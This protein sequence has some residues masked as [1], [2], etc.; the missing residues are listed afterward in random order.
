MDQE[1]L[2]PIV[3]FILAFLSLFALKINA[4]ESKVYCSTRKQL[5]SVIGD[6][7]TDI[8]AVLTV[9]FHATFNLIVYGGVLNDKPFI[10]MYENVADYYRTVQLSTLQTSFDNDEDNKNINL[11]LIETVLFSKNTDKIRIATSIQAIDTQSANTFYIVSTFDQ[12][13]VQQ[14]SVKIRADLNNP[15]NPHHIFFNEFNQVYMFFNLQD[16]GYI[17]KLSSDT[18]QFLY[19]V[20][21]NL[22]AG[23]FKSQISSILYNYDGRLMFFGDAFSVLGGNQVSKFYFGAIDDYSTDG[24]ATYICYVEKAEITDTYDLMTFGCL[25]NYKNEDQ[26][27]NVI[28]LMYWDLSS[29]FINFVYKVVNNASVKKL[30]CA[31]QYISTSGKISVYYQN[32]QSDNSYSIFYLEYDIS[33]NGLDV[34]YYATSYHSIQVGLQLNQQGSVQVKLNSF[35]FLAYTDQLLQGLAVGSINKDASNNQYRAGFIEGSITP[36]S[37]NYMDLQYTIEPPLENTFLILMVYLNSGGQNINAAIENF[38]PINIQK[39]EDILLT[40]NNYWPNQNPQTGSPNLKETLYIEPNQLIT[41][42]L[43]YDCNFKIASYQLDN[44]YENDLVYY[45]A[46]REQEG[47]NY[48][49][50]TEPD[51]FF[52]ETFIEFKQP[53]LNKTVTLSY[54]P[55]SVTLRKKTFNLTYSL[56]KVIVNQYSCFREIPFQMEVQTL[57]EFSFKMLEYPVPYLYYYP[58]SSQTQIVEKTTQSQY[59]VFTNLTK[60]IGT[61]F[62]STQIDFYGQQENITLLQDWQIIVLGPNYYTQYQDS[63]KDVNPEFHNQPQD[64]FMLAGTQRKVKLPSIKNDFGQK[65]I[66]ELQGGQ[67]TKFISLNKDQLVLSPSKEINGQFSINI[68]LRKFSQNSP[69]SS[70]IINVEVEKSKAIDPDKINL[71]DYNIPSSSSSTSI[72][73]K[74]LKAVQINLYLRITQV[75]D[76]LVIQ[77]KENYLFQ[78]KDMKMSITKNYEISKSLPPQIS[79]SLQAQLTKFGDGA[80]SSF[81]SF[82]GSNFAINLLLNLSWILTF[83]YITDSLGSLLSIILFV[84]CMIFPIISVYAVSYIKLQFPIYFKARFSPFDEGVKDSLYLI[85]LKPYL[86]PTKNYFEIFSETCIITIIYGFIPFLDFYKLDDEL[87]MN[88]GYLTILLTGLFIFVNLGYMI[89]LQMGD[90][91][92]KLKCVKQKIQINNNT[93][94]QSQNADNQLNTQQQQSNHLTSIDQSTIFTELDMDQKPI[95]IQKAQKRKTNQRRKTA[96]NMDLHL[97]MPAQTLRKQTDVNSGFQKNLKKVLDIPTPSNINDIQ[98]LKI[99]KKIFGKHHRKQIQINN[100]NRKFTVE[101]F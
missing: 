72:Q 94:M 2:K 55:Q 95:K 99:K 23:A 39:A 9:D 44:C 65:I 54:T 6:Y 63:S 26:T 81:Q 4:L 58:L 34:I 76:K 32:Q 37:W 36:Q 18:L 30:K 1:N 82:M 86:D 12:S 42:L 66:I 62:V 50:V 71:A 61:Y 70:Y 88:L 59:D 98:Q 21:L 13:L 8:S 90:L 40:K 31:G 51:T 11:K 96:V 24:Q 5:P 45:Y 97:Q 56:C 78:D 87:Q 91:C 48:F 10:G 28:G 46:F 80:S 17:A 29:T 83:I 7:E 20:T 33:L 64:I 3:L 14:N 52:T 41:C 79:E 93:S 60:D 16:R 84:F 22:E 74:F 100:H 69:G 15:F 53:I 35:L 47:N 89:S 57:C 68:G 77:F 38:V 101:D 92:R 85:Q 19:V 73:N 75:P 27:S 49:S 67:A 25:S 43:S